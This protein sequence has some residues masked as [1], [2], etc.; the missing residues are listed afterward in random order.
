MAAPLR[1]DQHALCVTIIFK[2]SCLELKLKARLLRLALLDCL[3]R[4]SWLNSAC[5]LGSTCT[6]HHGLVHA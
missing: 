1:H 4:A 6:K 5:N 3:F 2:E